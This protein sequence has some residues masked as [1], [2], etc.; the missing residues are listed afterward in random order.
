MIE[1]GILLPTRESVMNDRPAVG[2]MLA[3]AEQ[4][5]ALG[6][7]SVWVGD[8]LT[9]RPRHEPLTLLAAVAART[10]RVTLGTAVLLPALRH[11]LVLAHAVATVDRV[12]EGRLVLGVGIAGDTPATRKEF[13]AAGVPFRQRAGRCIETLD[14]CR[15]L[16]R[17]DSVSFQGRYWTLDGIA[18]GPTPHRPGGPLIWWGGGGPTALREA[19]R[20]HG[21]FPIDP[22]LE[23]F[24]EGWNRIQSAAR[25]AGRPPQDLTA[26][27]YTTIVLGEPAKAQAEIEQFLST[28]Y[29]APAAA[30]LK[31]QAC[32]AGAAEGCLEWMARF[33]ER[34]VRHILIRFAGASG[35]M[36]QLERA[37]R[38]LLP[39]VTRLV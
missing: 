30:M 25:D 8:S 32:Y 26:A 33:V 21:W 35:Q 11:P 27:L 16:W 14:I 17:G 6:F 23:L 19:A 4:A 5:E 20:S 3:L 12:A 34:G 36:A 13:E 2:P 10:R 39:R 38:D 15:A 29:N 1:V 24:Q 28:Y 9:A 31:R 22:R 7:S 37:A 18:I